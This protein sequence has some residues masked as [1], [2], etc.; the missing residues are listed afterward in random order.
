M[1]VG[2]RLMTFVCVPLALLLFLYNLRAYPSLV[3][4]RKGSSIAS[5]SERQR[6]ASR[7]AAARSMRH[8]NKWAGKADEDVKAGGEHSAD[9]FTSSAAGAPSS[10]DYEG[11]GEGEDEAALPVEAR[12]APTAAHSTQK[13]EV[14][15][16]LPLGDSVAGNA[17]A[18]LQDATAANQLS[19]IV[20]SVYSGAVSTAN[21]AA[22]AAAHVGERLRAS[23]SNQ[24]CKQ[25]RAFHRLR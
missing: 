7:Y 15:G 18:T 3:G 5:T 1:A 11:E 12:A 13:A 8:L 17:V 10:D 20:S 9:E 4:E 22:A 23:A 14:R 2:M 24:A 21:A 19:S 16:T 25:I 6:H